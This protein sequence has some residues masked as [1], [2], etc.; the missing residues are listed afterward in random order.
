MLETGKELRKSVASSTI[1]V[2]CLTGVGYVIGFLTQ[3]IIAHFFGVSKELDAFIAAAVIPEFIFGMTS[4]V[5][6]VSFVVIFAECV[7]ENGEEEAK[8]YVRK[9]FTFSFII[10]VCIIILLIALA[11]VLAKIIAPG[12]SEEQIALTARLIKIISIAVFFFGLSNL[13]SG[14]LYHEHKF[15][16][17]KALRIILGLGIIL[18]IVV[19]HKEFGV[20]SL[21]IGTII[22]IIV[23]FLIGYAAVRKQK[24]TF[25]FLFDRKDKFL[26]QILV[27]SWPLMIT[28]VLYYVNKILINIIASGLEQGAISIVNYAFLVSNVP[29][30]LFSESI[31]AAIF[32]HMTKLLTY[33]EAAQVKKL[34]TKSIQI[35]LVLLNPVMAIFMML[36]HELI[37]MVFQRGAFTTHST[38]AV[39]AALFFF[40]IGLVPAGIYTLILQLFYAKKEMKTQMYLFT[41]FLI[42]NISLI[43]ILV[44]FMSYNGIALGT[45]ISYWCVSIIA[46]LYIGNKINGLGYKEIGKT[47]LKV[48]PAT[49]LMVIA[50]FLLKSIAYSFVGLVIVLLL[51]VLIYVVSLQLMRSEE[52]KIMSDLLHEQ[53]KNMMSV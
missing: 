48:I 16:A 15:F 12:F 13:T 41:F 25:S 28:G 30:I 51:A 20:L 46:C 36:N 33:G 47:V 38:D 27:L 19:F 32:P 7:K 24:Y 44:Q 35:L 42:L 1:L 11:P 2:L 26:T 39:S 5:L 9:L 31:A 14:I 6:F 23:A 45:S 43:L 18:G 21:A 53:F 8:K 40:S 4:T 52:I 37:Q 22:G 29:V 34:V 50:I 3:I 17:T 49:V 10:L